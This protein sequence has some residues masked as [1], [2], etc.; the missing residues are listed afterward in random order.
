MIA[1]DIELAIA[2]HFNYRTCLIV[3]N[4]SWGWGLRYEADMVIVRESMWA[5]EI[6]IKVS[7]ADI[8]ADLNKK[9]WAHTS[10]RFRMLWFAV[11]EF[12]KSDPNINERAGILSVSEKGGV[13]VVR[14]PKL[15]PVAKK[16]TPNQYNKL[17]ELAAM[18]VWSLKS[19]LYAQ[20]QRFH[21]LANKPVLNSVQTENSCKKELAKSDLCDIIT[22]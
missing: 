8:K 11:P 3:P 4:V 6:E 10:D 15:N 19:A 7:S 2:E 16:V 14:T 9:S 18:R 13:E 17:L 20:Q 22:V 21:A 5:M 12:L 1:K